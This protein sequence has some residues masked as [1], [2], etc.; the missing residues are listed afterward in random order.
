MSLSFGP[1]G[2]K[3]TTGPRGKRATVGIP[4]T[5]L[6]YTSTLPSGGSGDRRN[7]SSAAPEVPSVREEDRLTLG[8]FKRLLTPDDEEALVDSCREL[9]S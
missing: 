5:G 7:T 9:E 6:F 3:F 8:F 1:R 2:A 4:G